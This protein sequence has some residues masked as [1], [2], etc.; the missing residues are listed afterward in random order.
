MEEWPFWPQGIRFPI[1]SLV[2]FYPDFVGYFLSRP[3][4][5]K[6]K[7]KKQ[8]HSINIK[9]TAISLFDYIYVYIYY[10]ADF[11][12]LHRLV[13]SLCN[14]CGIRQRKARRAA[15]AAVSSRLIPTA[16]AVAANK[17]GKDK[18]SDVDCIVPFKKRCRFSAAGGAAQK[19]L[20]F[21]D[22]VIRLSKSSA[23]HRVFPQDEKDAA[24]LLMAIS[25][26]LM[27]S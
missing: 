16:A 10:Q 15:A 2:I 19:A 25:C 26:G 11:S 5:K 7:N 22:I 8:Y 12:F 17:V 21:D 27:C 18:D 1:F 4:G 3:E 20:C 6:K 9:L 23:F 13:Q 14:A 24:I